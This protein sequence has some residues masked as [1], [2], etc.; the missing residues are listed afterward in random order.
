MNLICCSRTTVTEL[1]WSVSILFRNVHN[2]ITQEKMTVKTGNSILTINTKFSTLYSPRCTAV[3][4]STEGSCALVSIRIRLLQV[5]STRVG[6]CA[7][8]SVVWSS[9]RLCSYG[10]GNEP[11]DYLR[12]IAWRPCSNALHAPYTSLHIYLPSRSLSSV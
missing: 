10:R 8:L 1:Q 11:A 4:R 7:V 12:R 9:L 5:T 3:F 6:S 2:S